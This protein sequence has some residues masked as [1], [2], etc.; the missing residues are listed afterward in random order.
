MCRLP[1]T[2]GTGDLNCNL[3]KI[4][5]QYVNKIIGDYQCGFRRISTNDY[6][7]SAYVK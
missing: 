3:C 6:I 7:H 4:Y 2:R 1:L 5:G